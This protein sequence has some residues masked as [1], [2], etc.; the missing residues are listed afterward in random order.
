MQHPFKTDETIYFLDGRDWVQG[1][2]D[3]CY[4][5]TNGTLCVH[6]YN[7]RNVYAIDCMSTAEYWNRRAVQLQAALA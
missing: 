6:L 3:H 4:R 5:S 2:V 7:G 1:K